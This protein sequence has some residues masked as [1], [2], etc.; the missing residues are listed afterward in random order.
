MPL[1]KGKSKKV[2]SRNVA[3]LMHSGRPKKQA[4]AMKK[5]GKS[6]KKAKRSASY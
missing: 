5:A 6:R 3:E 4:V 2:V 1:F